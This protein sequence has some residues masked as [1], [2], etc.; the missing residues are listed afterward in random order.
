MIWIRYKHSKLASIISAFGA[1]AIVCGFYLLGSA[2][3]FVS[4][5]EGTGSVAGDV[6]GGILCL[7]VGAVLMFAASKVAA[8]K[9]IKYQEKM[10]AKAAAKE[11]KS[12]SAPKKKS[13]K[14]KIVGIILIALQVVAIVFSIYQGN[15]IW[16]QARY[17]PAGTAMGL[18]LGYFL[19]TIIGVILII[20]GN[21]KTVAPDEKMVLSKSTVAESTVSSESTE[22]YTVRDTST[23]AASYESA[24]RARICPKCGAEA[25]EG[26]NFCIYCGSPVRK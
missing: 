11:A 10:A 1:V 6:V 20:R 13:G 18:Y 15:P 2:I 19:P 4:A 25:E 23:E 22:A 9:E 17:Q 26:E 5:S 3:G 21:K 7:A 16:V 24:K 12:K 8:S 14:G